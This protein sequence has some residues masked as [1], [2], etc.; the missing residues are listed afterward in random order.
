MSDVT[1]AE[2]VKM[3]PVEAPLTEEVLS[4]LENLES[5]SPQQIDVVAK[6]TIAKKTINC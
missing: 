2:F 1:F 4:N 5:L 6:L 3:L